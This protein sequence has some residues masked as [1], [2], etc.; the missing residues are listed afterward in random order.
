MGR[1]LLVAF[2]ALFVIGTLG[3]LRPSYAEVN[4]VAIATISERHRNIVI[5]AF[6]SYSTDYFMNPDNIQL[7][8]RIEEVGNGKIELAVYNNHITQT[9]LVLSA[10]AV[11]G[12]MIIPRGETPRMFIQEIEF[13]DIIF[14]YIVYDI[15]DSVERFRDDHVRHHG[16]SWASFQPSRSRRTAETLMS[17]ALVNNIDA[18]SQ[19]HVSISFN[20]SDYDN[21]NVLFTTKVRIENRCYWSTAQNSNDTFS[22]LITQA[23]NDILGYFERTFGAKIEY[24][25]L[26]E[27]DDISFLLIFSGKW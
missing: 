14:L 7:L 15:M 25:R 11:D 12:R 26:E 5:S 10:L 27:F 17:N 18:A 4:Y 23:S 24:H 22:N 6:D 8:Y 21:V 19:A 1:Y 2:V 9:L 16:M 20:F 13:N 3:I